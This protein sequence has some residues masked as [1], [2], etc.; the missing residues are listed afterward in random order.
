LPPLFEDIERRTFDFF[1]STGNRF[2]GMVPDRFPTPAPA[3]IAAIGSFA[4][5]SYVI[6]VDSRLHHACL[7]RPGTHVDDGLRFFRE[8]RKACRALA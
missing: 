3:S 6:G 1:W 5:T 7:P 2:N 8:R 4:L